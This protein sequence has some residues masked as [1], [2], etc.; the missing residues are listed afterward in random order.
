LAIVED[1]RDLV[2]VLLLLFKKLNIRVCF[3]A[4]DGREALEKFIET[5]PKPHVVIMDYR[6]PTMNGIEVTREML[7]IDP[8]TRVIFM[9]ADA[10]VEDEA[11]AAGAV[12]FLKK[13]ASIRDIDAAIQ[14]IM[15]KYPYIKIYAD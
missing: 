13:P 5:T 11:L 1:E 15:K 10:A 12:V 6:L 2:R 9:S 7:K 3:I 4:Y 14:D 8:Q